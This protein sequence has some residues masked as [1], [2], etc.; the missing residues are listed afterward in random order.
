MQLVYNFRDRRKAGN[1][2][3]IATVF[4]EMASLEVPCPVIMCQYFY[5]LILSHLS[6]FSPYR[7]CIYMMASSF[8]CLLDF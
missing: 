2:S 3:G 6:I 8:M 1:D 7:F 4:L 5:I